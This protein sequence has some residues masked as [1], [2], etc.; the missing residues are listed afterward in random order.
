MYPSLVVAAAMRYSFRGR[1]IFLMISV[2]KQC[3]GL[4]Y[5]WH[6]N[7]LAHRLKSRPLFADCTMVLCQRQVYAILIDDVTP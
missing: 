1:L 4:M 5:S 6:A 3:C 7:D 2:F